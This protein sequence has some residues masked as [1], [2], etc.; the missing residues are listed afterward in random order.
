MFSFKQI[1]LVEMPISP[2]TLRVESKV[3]VGWLLGM[4]P[5]RL[6]MFHVILVTANGARGSPKI[7]PLQ[8]LKRQVF[9]KFHQPRFPLQIAGDFPLLN[10][11][12]EGEGP[13]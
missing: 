8:I 7:L 12:I 9:P 2:P 10:H 6:Q 3:K 5:P 4:P 11:H 13:V 1:Y